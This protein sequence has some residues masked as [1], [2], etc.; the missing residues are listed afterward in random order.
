[1]SW[2]YVISLYLGPKFRVVHIS[3]EEKHLQVLHTVCWR[4][5]KTLLKDKLL[6]FQNFCASPSNCVSLLQGKHFFFLLIIQEGRWEN[7]KVNLR[8][9][10]LISINCLC[11]TVILS[12]TTV[13]SISEKTHYQ[14][15]K[16]A[17]EPGI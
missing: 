2:Y 16:S 4:S 13:V 7:L 1:M 17:R 3:V 6:L 14:N 11:D 8:M 9:E 5:A 15:I 10:V 12:K